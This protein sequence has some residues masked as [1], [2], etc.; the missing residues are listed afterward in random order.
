MSLAPPNC[1]QYFVNSTGNIQ[2]FNYASSV[3]G[4]FNSLGVQGSRQI[5]NL[6]YTICVRQDPLMCAII[7]EIPS[8]DSYAFTLTGDATSVDYTIL[9][10][11]A[12]QS[13]TC[14]TDYIII[15][16]Q[17][18]KVNGVWTPLASSYS[19][20]LGFAPKLSKIVFSAFL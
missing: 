14:T 4:Q 5:A 13:Q 9:G 12:V 10:T 17:Q 11:S 2:S 19:C 20:G 8:T 18:Q 7:Y 6:N 1:L 16:G 15:P 3:S